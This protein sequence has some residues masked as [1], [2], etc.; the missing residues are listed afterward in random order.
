MVIAIDGP[1]GSGKSTVAYLLAKKLR[2]RYVDSGAFYRA[3]AWKAIEEKIDIANEDALLALAEKSEFTLKEVNCEVKFFCDG[4]DITKSLRSPEVTRI[5]AIVA[6]YPKVRMRIVNLIRSLVGT[7]N[8]VVEGR[9]IGTVVF[10][11]AEY[12]FF[13]IADEETRAKRKYKEL[14]SYGH[15]VNYE[16]VKEEIESRNH[17]DKKRSISP[18]QIAPNSIIIDTSKFTAEQII[19][20]LLQ[21]LNLKNILTD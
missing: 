3:L 6:Q 20:I 17:L 1:A 8:A 2:F 5:V 19:E 21:H 18:L 10:P 11:E 15:K 16:Q 9:D 7:S 4:R 14:L 12:K 13:L